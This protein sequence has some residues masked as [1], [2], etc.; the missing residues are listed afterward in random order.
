MAEAP[1]MTA[2]IPNSVIDNM[3]KE[4]TPA[5]DPTITKFAQPRHRIALPGNGELE[6][7]QSGIRKALED[8]ADWQR[9]LALYSDNL[10]VSID[11]IRR[12]V[13]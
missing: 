12:G 7:I 1:S 5:P 13:G 10:K 2:P 4:L 11:S 8:L 6:G 3:E 9:Q